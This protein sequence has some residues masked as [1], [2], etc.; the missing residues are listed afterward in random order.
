MVKESRSAGPK[1]SVAPSQQNFTVVRAVDQPNAAKHFWAALVQL[2]MP[3]FAG[4]NIQRKIDVHIQEFFNLL[5]LSWES[6]SLCLCIAHQ[7]VFAAWCIC[8]GSLEGASDVDFKMDG[9]EALFSTCH[10]WQP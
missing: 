5:H 1:S 7:V 3:A 6:T 10:R 2:V 9:N 8:D 4:D